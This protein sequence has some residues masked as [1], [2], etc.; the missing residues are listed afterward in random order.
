MT[1]LTKQLQYLGFDDRQAKAYLALLEL[2]E[3]TL[4]ELVKR[5]KIKR[6]TLYDIVRS[7][8]DRG[9]VST[10]KRGERTTY[11]A[12]D[13]RTLDERL[14]EQRVV[15]ADALPELLSLAN[16]LNKKPR[17]LYYEGAEGI[18]EV[19]RNTLEYPNQELLAW[20]T[21]DAVTRFDLDFLNTIYLPKRIEKKIW[22]RAIVPDVPRMCEYL[23][24]DVASL[25]TTRVMDPA[26]F[27]LD[28]EINLYGGSR[29]AF[30]S[31]REQTGLIVENASM[32]RTLKSIFE[33]Q[34]ESVG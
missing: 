29:V 22:V 5:S 8:R 2:G 15:L 3:G 25:R 32:Y 16:A 4:A 34:W 31:F 21:E 1:S 30:M 14:Q 23:G 7:L 17:I 13:P 33:Q 28:V 6:T 24:P 9:L 19:Y 27:P 20:V 11:I 10:A 26:R 18:K 12:E